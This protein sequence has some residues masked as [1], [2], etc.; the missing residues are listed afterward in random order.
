MALQPTVRPR[1]V[2]TLIK[3]QLHSICSS[4]PLVATKGS[5]QEMT[6]VG[7][8][9]VGNGESCGVAPSCP[10][11]AAK[12]AGQFSRHTVP[13]SNG[14]PRPS[15]APQLHSRLPLTEPVSLFSRKE[16]LWNDK[17]PFS[18]EDGVD[19]PFDRGISLDLRVPHPSHCCASLLEVSKPA[20]IHRADIW[21]SAG[22]G[23]AQDV[24]L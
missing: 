8:H 12:P 7:W 2:T 9:Q 10:G 5:L 23:G 4:M 17:P 24:F 11:T 18:R 3:S 13:C 20:G 14:T 6:S 15:L 21:G 19:H 22:K 1:L 16:Q